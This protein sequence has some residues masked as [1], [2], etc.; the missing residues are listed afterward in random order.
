MNRPPD[1]RSVRS[2]Q[3]HGRL[4]LTGNDDHTIADLTVLLNPSVLTNPTAAPIHPSPAATIADLI[5]YALPGI[6]LPR[7]P[8][9]R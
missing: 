7:V 1:R 8:S 4:P 9:H 6:R 3:E 2:D 5:R